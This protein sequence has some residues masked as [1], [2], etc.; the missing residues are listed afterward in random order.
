MSFPFCLFFPLFCCSGYI[1]STHNMLGLRLAEQFTMYNE[2]MN[3][4]IDNENVCTLIDELF[5]ASFLPIL[6]HC[7]ACYGENISFILCVEQQFVITINIQFKSFGVR[8]LLAF[9][10]QYKTT[11]T[12]T[13]V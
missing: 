7:V 2:K 9:I 12:S 11:S 13:T 3:V 8:G 10:V 4:K 1:F 6:L 5:F